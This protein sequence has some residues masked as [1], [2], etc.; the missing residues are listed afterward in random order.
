MKTLAAL[1]LVGLL[2]AGC[3]SPHRSDAG[4]P[5]PGAQAYAFGPASTPAQ[6][7]DGFGTEPSLLASHDRA[8]YFTSVLGSATARGDGLWRS[9]DQGKT[10]TYLGKADYPFGGGDSDIDELSDGSLLLTGQ[11]R[12]AAAPANPVASPYVTGGESVSRSTD[13]GSTW[14]AFPA[15][16]YFPDA[17]RN[18]IATDG[19]STAYLVFNVGVTGLEVGKSTDG[20]KTW[21]PPTLVDASTDA[22][23]SG[24][25]GIAGDAVVDANGTL[26][27]PYGPGPGGGTV[28]R[29]LRSTDG[30]ATFTSLEAHHTP[31][32][33][34]SGAIFSSLA[35]DSAGGLYLVWAESTSPLP[36]APHQPTMAIL[37]SHSEDQGTT[38]SDPVRASPDGDFSAVFPWVVAGAPGHVAVGYYGTANLTLPDDAPDGT[39]WHP[40][41]SFSSDARSPTAVFTAARATPTPNH[42][43]PICTGGTGCSSGRTLGDF[44]EV[45]MQPDGK[46]AIVWADDTGSA[47][48]NR[49][50]VQTAGPGLLG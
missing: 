16:G 50:A 31:A 28:Q 8:L 3:S 6:A 24:P 34:S 41:V 14:T 36:P 33:E 1:A 47:Q 48:A 5:G 22:V 15:A 29:V 4:K 35:L 49:V 9:T 37:L 19:P 26:Y 11:W 23:P 42:K 2:A 32:S 39:F 38:W 43:G 7:P 44:F 18:W 21:F 13:H 12:P 40:T 27:I 17:D 20:G 45:A 10:W 46:V 25:N 30:G